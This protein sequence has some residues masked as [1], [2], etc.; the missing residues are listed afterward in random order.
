LQHNASGC[1]NLPQCPKREETVT[2]KPK[3]GSSKNRLSVSVTDSELTELLSLKDR[4]RVSVAWLG[5]QAIVEFI[6]KY[7][8]EHVQLPLKL[9]MRS[10]H[11][12][13]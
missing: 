8:E 7:R 9:T 10:V 5:R 3:S 4:H 11:D 1:C 6:A 12:H 2:P 13:S